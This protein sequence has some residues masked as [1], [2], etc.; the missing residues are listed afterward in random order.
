MFD[1][2]IDLPSYCD[3]QLHFLGI[4]SKFVLFRWFTYLLSI[5][6]VYISLKFTF[7]CTDTSRL[8]SINYSLNI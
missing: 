1:W 7:V 8:S 3:F 6:D 2:D 4:V 5:N